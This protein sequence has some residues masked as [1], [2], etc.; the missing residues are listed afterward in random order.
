M[1]LNSKGQLTIPA[2][3]RHRHGLHNGDEL[4]V[5]E[6]DGFLCIVRANG[7]SRG[8]RL[9]RRMRGRADTGFSTDELL[10]LLR[11]GSRPP[12]AGTPPATGPASRPSS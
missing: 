11:D 7:P 10:G 9:V 1:R 6:R 3:L 5:V 8:D 12:P 4:D 2:Q